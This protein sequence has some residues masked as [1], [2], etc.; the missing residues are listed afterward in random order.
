MEFACITKLIIL[1]Y[2]L[3]AEYR[4]QFES[5]VC[6]NIKIIIIITINN[7]SVIIFQCLYILKLN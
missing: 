5:I 6:H 1:V 4:I 7:N 2:N 3:L